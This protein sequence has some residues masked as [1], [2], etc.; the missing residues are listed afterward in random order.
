MISIF[1]NTN[2][3]EKS[4]T[5]N[6]E[7]TDARSVVNFHKSFPNYEPTPLINLTG[8]TKKI[9][10]SKIWIKDESHRF[11][12]NAFKVL[13]ASYAAAKIVSEKF[14]LG[15]SPL[16]FDIFNNPNIRRQIKN[17]TL[18]TATDGNHGRGVAWT[19]KQLGCKCVVY[20]PKGTTQARFENIKSHGAEV[21]IINGSYDEAV[22]IA[23]TNSELYG[24]ILIQD[25]SWPG[26]EKIPGWIMNGYSTL[27]HE[28][29]YQ[30]NGETPTHIFVQCGVGSLPAAILDYCRIN[31]K[32]TRPIFINVEPNDA[33]CVFESVKNKKIISLKNEMTSIMA[34]LCCGT[35]SKIAFDILFEHADHFICCSDDLTELGMNIL[36]KPLSADTKIISGESGAVTTGLVYSLMTDGNYQH[37][38]NK[39]GLNENSKILLFSTEGDTDPHMYSK[40]LT[41]KFNGE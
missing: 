37:I 15:N 41:K 1:E 16:S 27:M 11:G 39:I 10:V 14:N 4:F 9:G 38:K 5:S 22:S 36:G 35:P 12:L 17:I 13:G 26:Y 34:G 32:Q 19:A 29:D 25:T 30:L 31:Y 6:H 2:G 40:I 33:A 3:V 21:S 7:L 28:I 24:W 23:K 20:M 8:L 18:A